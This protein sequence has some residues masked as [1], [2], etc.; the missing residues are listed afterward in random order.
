[1]KWKESWELPTIPDPVFWPEVGR[2]RGA[3]GG[4]KPKSLRPCEFC[5]EQHGARDMQRHLP[6]CPKRP[7]ATKA[8]GEIMNASLA[9]PS[10]VTN[11][12]YMQLI[13]TVGRASQKMQKDAAELASLL[14]AKGLKPLTSQDAKRLKMIMNRLDRQEIIL[15]G[16]LNPSK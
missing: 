5:G 12:P 8:N 3:T 11:H 10:N 15:T 13:E 4:G 1:M 16:H 6:R 14:S 2:R 9:I 7:N